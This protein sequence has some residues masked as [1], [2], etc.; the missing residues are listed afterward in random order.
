MTET[1]HELAGKVEGLPARIYAY[2]CW[3][4]D[5][6]YWKPAPWPFECEH[7]VYTRSDL[8]SDAVNA[9]EEARRVIDGVDD[10]LA[11]DL[12]LGRVSSGAY[13]FERS[14]EMEDAIAKIDAAL[15][16]IKGGPTP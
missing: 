14:G 10:S 4:S 7:T 11:A 12:E 16:R 1:L 5:S 9:L 3:N 2:E 13:V 15:N 8:V 6:G